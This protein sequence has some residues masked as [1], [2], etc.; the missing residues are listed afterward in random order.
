MNRK[1]KAISVLFLPIFD[2][3]LLKLKLTCDSWSQLYHQDLLLFHTHTTCY[4]EDAQG[5]LYFQEPNSLLG[6]TPKLRIQHNM[7]IRV[8]IKVDLGCYGVIKEEQEK[9][10]VKVVVNRVRKQVIRRNN[11]E[12][13][14]KEAIPSWALN[15]YSRKLATVVYT[16]ENTLVGIKLGLVA[17]TRMQ[18]RGSLN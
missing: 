5:V 9:R 4:L 2:S 14:Q 17:E 10:M 3:S 1:D 8:I 18:N 13:F 15:L 7:L 12:S 6:E 11:R 16:V